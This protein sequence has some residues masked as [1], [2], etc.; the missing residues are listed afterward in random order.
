[1]KI[2]VFEYITAFY[3]SPGGSSEQIYLFY[4]EVSGSGAKYK[5]TGGLLGHGED[6]IHGPD[7]RIF[8]CRAPFALVRVAEPSRGSPP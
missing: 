6:V 3:P 4:S 2:D 5:E 1:M 7:Q 8:Q